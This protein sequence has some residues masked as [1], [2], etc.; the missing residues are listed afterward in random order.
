[1]CWLPPVMNLNTT[2]ATTYTVRKLNA[3]RE[4]SAP[5]LP[6]LPCDGYDGCATAAG[7]CT[8]SLPT[9][10]VTVTR[11]HMPQ[12]QAALRPTWQAA[13]QLAFP[14][15][16]LQTGGGCCTHLILACCCTAPPHRAAT[17]TQNLA[18]SAAPCSS[19][20]TAGAQ[21]RGSAAERPCRQALAPP[22]RG[23]WCQHRSAFAAYV[24]PRWH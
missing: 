2:P 9:A 22:S 14:P 7:T 1:M 18:P 19:S 24:M 8:A 11:V 4:L 10:L 3:S 6:L 21:Q 15:Y 23:Q 5:A 17:A 20:H 16:N 12:S 13:V